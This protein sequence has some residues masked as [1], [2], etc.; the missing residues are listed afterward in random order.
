MNDRLKYETW[1]Q[2][3][4]LT[5]EEQDDIIETKCEIDRYM[6]TFINMENQNEN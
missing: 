3:C 5:K 1:V 2:W 6:Q 4:A